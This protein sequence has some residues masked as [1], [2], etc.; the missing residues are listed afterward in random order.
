MLSYYKPYKCQY[1]GCNKTIFNYNNKYNYFKSHFSNM[2]CTEHRYVILNFKLNSSVQNER[3]HLINRR[4]Y[5]GYYSRSVSK[6]VI[7]LF[8]TDTF[9]I[10]ETFSK[11][12]P[13]FFHTENTHCNKY[14]WYINVTF[15][16]VNK[17]NAFKRSYTK[18]IC[19]GKIPPTY[20]MVSCRDEFVL[21]SENFHR[22]GFFI[23][24]VSKEFHGDKKCF[25]SLQLAIDYLIFEH[26]IG[27]EQLDVERK[28][29][30]SLKNSYSRFVTDPWT[31]KQITSFFIGNYFCGREL[32]LY[33][34][35]LPELADYIAFGIYNTY[36]T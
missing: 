20:K 32:E 34:Y 25:T 9:Y 16:K 12:I 19:Y 23:Q 7:E 5:V 10:W 29:C 8:Q 33:D 27:H 11:Q 4:D 3:Q 1:I 2:Y 24:G 13:E 36:K 15:V 18:S 26:L 22:Y 35:L 6:Y 14:E 28:I 31:L 30:L 17:K 21:C